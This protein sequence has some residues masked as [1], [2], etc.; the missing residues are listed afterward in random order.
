MVGLVRRLLLLRGRAVEFDQSGGL[1]F[2]W[3]RVVVFLA[4]S[5]WLGLEG[6]VVVLYLI[7]P[8]AGGWLLV[9]FGLVWACRMDD[10]GLDVFL[11]R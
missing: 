4:A 3:T 1:F 7:C 11:I 5:A 8:V 2:F 6:V 9:C 10:D